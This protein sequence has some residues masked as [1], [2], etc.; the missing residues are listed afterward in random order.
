MMASTEF[1]NSST[2]STFP[3]FPAASFTSE[4]DDF[5]MAQSEGKGKDKCHPEKP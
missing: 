2:F 5:T 3:I 1:S 4:T